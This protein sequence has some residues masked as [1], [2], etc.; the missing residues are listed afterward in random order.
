MLKIILGLSNLFYFAQ[1]PI[2]FIN[3]FIIYIF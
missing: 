3:L 1:T 2:F